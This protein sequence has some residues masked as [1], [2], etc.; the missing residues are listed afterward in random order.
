MT[1]AERPTDTWADRI[2][3]GEPFERHV[4]D[5]IWQRDWQVQKFGKGLLNGVV[6]DLLT[7][8]RSP[9]GAETLSRW[10]PDMI[11]IRAFP[12]R[13]RAWL[14]DAKDGDKHKTTGNHDVE[15]RALEA[16]E[17]F[18]QAWGIPSLFVFGDMFT[19]TPAVVRAHGT[20]GR[21]PAAHRTRFL[22]F[23]KAVCTP[24]DD[25][26]GAMRSWGPA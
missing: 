2:G 13:V 12:D 20:E 26:F 22:V 7:R 1:I 16:A 17:A 14:V 9:D 24:F 4:S 11:A 15:I 19:A 3:I 10:G 8:Y 5:E 25:V 6:Q 18:T 23:P 21:R